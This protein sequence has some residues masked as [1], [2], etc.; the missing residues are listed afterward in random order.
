MALKYPPKKQTAHVASDMYDG[1]EGN[2]ARVCPL[3][4]C[5]TV[6]IP[7]T[8]LS[9]FRFYWRI[10]GWVPVPLAEWY[11]CSR[12]NFCRICEDDIGNPGSQN[13]AHKFGIENVELAGFLRV[14]SIWLQLA[15]FF[16][17]DHSLVRRAGGWPAWNIQKPVLISPWTESYWSMRSFEFSTNTRIFYWSPLGSHLP[18]FLKATFWPRRRPSI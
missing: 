18:I 13:S 16:L 17:A 14:S 5:G 15:S 8:D 2:V 9:P 3:E 10:G 7:S 12:C 6:H 4:W 1:A 11:E